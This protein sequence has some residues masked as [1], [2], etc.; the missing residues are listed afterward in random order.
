MKLIFAKIFNEKIIAIVFTFAFMIP[1]SA[2]A[3]GLS[4]AKGI[5]DQFKTEL[6]TI[7]PV[8]AVIALIILGI[9]YATK[10]VDKSTFVRWAIGI[11]IAGSAAEITAIFFT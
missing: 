1:D 10:H 4:K 9:G 11:I 2:M 5:M 7:I 6:L 3:A 8:V